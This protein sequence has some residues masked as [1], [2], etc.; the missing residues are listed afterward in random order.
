MA[1]DDGVLSK[2]AGHRLDELV[3]NKVD[4]RR[5]LMSVLLSKL[6]L[7][8]I[9]GSLTVIHDGCKFVFQ[10][11]RQNYDPGA[12]SKQQ[13]QEMK[14]DWEKRV[15]H[16]AL[17][18][19]FHDLDKALRVLR[20]DPSAPLEL[21][22]KMSV[23]I[24]NDTWNIHFQVPVGRTVVPKELGGPL[25]LDSL[26]D[27]VTK[28]A[29]PFEKELT[30]KE[31]SALI[32]EYGKTLN[33]IQ[34]DA[35]Q[36]S[37]K[38][39]DWF[40]VGSPGDLWVFARGVKNDN[41]PY[42]LTSIKC[43]DPEPPK[44]GEPAV[45]YGKPVSSERI[46]LTLDGLDWPGQGESTDDVLTFRLYFL[47]EVEDC[48]LD[49]VQRFYGD[50]FR[51]AS[52]IVHKRIDGTPMNREHYLD[53]F[54]RALVLQGA[55]FNRKTAAQ[56]TD[57][58]VYP[59][60]MADLI[61]KKVHDIR[62]VRIGFPKPKDEDEEATK[63]INDWNDHI[64]GNSLQIG[65]EETIS[66]LG[67]TGWTVYN[68]QVQSSNRFNSVGAVIN[69]VPNERKLDA[70]VAGGDN[71]PKHIKDARAAIVRTINA[72]IEHALKWAA[73]SEGAIG[74][75]GK[76]MYS[77]QITVGSLKPTASSPFSLQFDVQMESVLKGKMF[78]ATK[79]ALPP[80]TAS[81]SP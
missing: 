74:P 81:P 31:H 12:L 15:L 8:D 14:E 65:I 7:R 3:A 77:E 63:L 27:M 25:P 6:A 55:A 49:I 10:V 36:N 78:E 57:A 56:F 17:D 35:H 41:P 60:D 21:S 68:V 5:K 32:A 29:I 71:V 43:K 70:E 13:T 1:V 30:P 37:G 18:E 23:R 4:F 42:P 33:A 11:D 76:H 38:L 24:L 79:A 50:L 22:S 80:S 72:H 34:V 20:E 52:V 61:G 54:V 58:P 59:P 19:Q 51:G 64:V 45:I 9:S 44:E 62:T 46:P 39:F 40:G 47:H 48:Y 69:V 67:A 28:Y 26:V 53:I 73:A 16:V 75:L 66:R 2:V